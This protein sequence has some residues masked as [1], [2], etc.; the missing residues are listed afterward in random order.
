MT[1][2]G[3][4]L[5]N[6][7][8]GFRTSSVNNREASDFA[9]NEQQ[10]GEAGNTVYL[11]RRVNPKDISVVYH[12]SANS[13]IEHKRK[14]D[15]L[16]NILSA[17]EIHFAFNDE[18]D[19]YYIGTVSNISAM[20]INSSGETIVSSTG[21]IR[22]RCSDPSKHSETTKTYTAAPDTNGILTITINNEGS[23]A[24]PIDYKITHNF[25]NGFIGIVSDKG[26]IELGRKEEIDSI[27]YKQNEVLGSLSAIMATADDHSTNYLHP[28]SA[29]TGELDEETF[30]GAY[31]AKLTTTGTE[32]EGKWCG[33]MKTLTIPADDEGYFGS[34]NFYSYMNHWFETGLI[35]QTGQQSVAFLTGDNRV[36]CA[37]NLFKSDIGSNTAYAEFWVNGKCVRSTKFTPS[38]YDE[39]NPF[40]WARGH[41]DIRKIGNKVT[42]YWWGTYPSFVD[43]A[44]ELLE[45]EKIQIAMSN[46][47]GRG[48][49]WADYLGGNRLKTVTFEK[50]NVADPKDVTNRYKAGDVIDIDGDTATIYLNGMVR[51]SEEVKGSVYFLAEPGET[52]IKFYYSSFCTTPPTITATITEVW[53]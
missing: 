47:Y 31:T 35:G 12:L 34:V 22:I 17:E 24:V 50:I 14:H 29:M 39:D 49:D 10:L 44:I 25:K 52:E 28:S 38:A 40:N 15:Q 46:F 20:M 1:V 11:S 36:I 23:A 3:S 2:N 8:P 5:E 13:L 32:V 16:K 41:N 45:C 33:G 19:G 30:N 27:A 6:L 48:V 42:F 7:V 53:L 26:V 9:I 51:T 18:P 4:Y 43:P 21:E 37:F